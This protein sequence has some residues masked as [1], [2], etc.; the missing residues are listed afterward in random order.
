M[1]I[2]LSLA[3]LS[4]LFVFATPISAAPADRAGHFDVTI[5]LER[6]DIVTYGPFWLGNPATL[7]LPV[8]SPTGTEQTR[9]V[10]G[11][12]KI[13]APFEVT[14]DIN[15]DFG[16]VIG[17]QSGTHAAEFHIIDNYQT[18]KGVVNWNC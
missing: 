11:T 15:G 7:T 18:G 9:T 8:G 10:P 12:L 14:G 17:A 4:S 6:I 3:L 13:H 1:A 5:N 2:A 16:P